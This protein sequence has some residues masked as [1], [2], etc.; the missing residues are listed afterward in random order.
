MNSEIKAMKEG[1]EQIETWLK[2][3]SPKHPD[4]KMMQSDLR[5]IERMIL[6]EKELL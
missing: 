1:K 6:N 5:R 3:H 4:Y 2:T